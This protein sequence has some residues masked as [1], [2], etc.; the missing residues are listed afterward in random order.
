VPP[1][2]PITFKVYVSAGFGAK[3][4]VRV[5]VFAGIS[6]VAG[7]AIAPSVI[8]APVIVQPVK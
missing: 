1:A 2:A 4:A 7:F 6:N 8:T 5:T 3:F